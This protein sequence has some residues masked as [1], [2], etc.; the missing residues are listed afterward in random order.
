ILSRIAQAT[1]LMVSANQVTH[2]AAQSALKR[3][4]AA[5]ANIIGAGLSHFTVG[6]FD[7]NYAYKYLNYYYYQYGEEA[8]Q[9]E[10]QGGQK[11]IARKPSSFLDRLGRSARDSLGR[12][13]QRLKPVD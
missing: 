9:L 6:R 5:G 8:P 1:L 11:A 13:A 3:L 4:R 10:G 12:I 2:K 7:Y